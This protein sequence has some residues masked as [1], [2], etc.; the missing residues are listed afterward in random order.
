MTDT[1]RFLALIAKRKLGNFTLKDIAALNALQK[2]YGLKA[3]DFKDLHQ[4]FNVK[5]L[6]E[7]IPDRGSVEESWERFSS[8]IKN[9]SQPNLAP[10][11]YYAKSY[12]VKKLVFALLTAAALLVVVFNVF[13]SDNFSS[14]KKL[15]IVSTE[16]GS[17]SKVQMPDGSLI[18]LNSGSTITYDDHYGIKN[19]NVSL[20]GEAYF[21]IKHD[22]GHPFII[23]TKSMR[24]K[25]LGTAFNVRAYKESMSS[26]A[27][28]IRGSLE[29]SFPSR[30]SEMIILKPKEKISIVHR[31]P[32][33]Q[34]TEPL[35]SGKTREAASIISL[36]K[37]GELTPLDDIEEISWVENKLIFR[38]KNFREL[39]IDLERWYNIKIDIKDT[40]MLEKKFT[41][42]FKNETFIEAINA[43]KETYQFD[44]NYNKNNNTVTI[45]SNK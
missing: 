32:E 36:S 33:K 13:R 8:K 21:D 14:T 37:I 26:E 31:V 18:W 3:E 2:E 25:V 27:T 4:I 5:Y 1:D 23:Q 39:S 9:N 29:V 40:I 7:G 17:K 44:Y 38:E 22:P 41:G 34:S 11:S 15:N 28:L 12:K 35:R 43:L 19:R 20:V 10:K 30:P 6:Q 42:T 45:I 24:L 16:H